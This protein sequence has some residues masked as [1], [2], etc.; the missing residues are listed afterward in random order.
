MAAIL[1]VDDNEAI[2]RLLSD[3]FTRAGFVVQ[4]ARGA[5][6]AMD[7]CRRDCFDVVLSDVLMPGTDGHALARHLAV[8]CPRTRV[9]LMSGYDP[10]CDNCPYAPRC[11]FI[12]KPFRPRHVV[13]YVSKIL[14]SPLPARSASSE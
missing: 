6:E 11:W 13:S 9:V 1:I 10:G 5:E 8:V 12:H 14:A 4:A 2:R 3:L 7:L